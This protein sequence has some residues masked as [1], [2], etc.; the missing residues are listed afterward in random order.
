MRV[1]GRY[2][3]RPETARAGRQVLCARVDAAG[4]PGH[5]KGKENTL[6]ATLN[7]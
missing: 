4:R 6:L 7:V 2:G 1:L 5:D 3:S